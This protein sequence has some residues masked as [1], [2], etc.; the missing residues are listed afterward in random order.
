MV[1]SSSVVVVDILSFLGSGSCGGDLV[2]SVFGFSIFSGVTGT[3]R[4]Y[5][6]TSL[7]QLF[8][9]KAISDLRFA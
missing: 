7:E 4:C 1:S 8:R 2:G 9:L 6:R 5:V 3:C